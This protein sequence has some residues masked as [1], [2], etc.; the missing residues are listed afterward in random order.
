V[1]SECRRGELRVESPSKPRTKRAYLLNCLKA[2]YSRFWT[3]TLSCFHFFL[4][5]L[6]SAT[7]NI[8]GSWTAISGASPQNPDIRWAPVLA[9]R[10]QATAGAASST[11]SSAA[12]LLGKRLGT[13]IINVALDIRLSHQP[14]TE[15]QRTCVS[16]PPPR[17]KRNAKQN[18]CRPSQDLPA[19]APQFLATRPTAS[20]SP[21]Q[22]QPRWRAPTL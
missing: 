3:S 13:V 5:C 12:S 9:E 11:R 7:N 18:K 15:A 17:E 16:L 8:Q 10:R 22:F 14:Q 20:G 21:P 4:A 1:C 19:P 6:N 2:W